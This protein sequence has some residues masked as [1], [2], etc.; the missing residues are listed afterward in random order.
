[1]ERRLGAHE[2]AIYR[3]GGRVLVPCEIEGVVD[4][5]L[6]AE[7]VRILTEFHPVL[8]GRFVPDGDSCVVRDGDPGTRR[9]SVETFTGLR[10]E[11]QVV[12]DWSAG[13]LLRVAVS[14]GGPRTTVALSLPRALVD[15]SA[16]IALYKRLWSVYTDLSLGRSVPTHVIAGGLAS[17]SLDTRVQEAFTEE[18][19]AGFL[20]S[21]AA[22]RATVPSVLPVRGREP[23]SFGLVR[24]ELDEEHTRRFADRAH[25]A[26]LS[27]HSL[28][29]GVLLTAAR[30]FLAP[31]SPRP[32][33]LACVS[34]VDLRSRISPPID[35]ES[36]QSS[37][38]SSTATLEVPESP[39]PVELGRLVAE[40]LRADLDAR[41]PDLD[42]ATI[43]R[44]TEK[45]VPRLPTLV[46]TNLHKIPRPRLPEG[47]AV[48]GW[49]ILPLVD[50]PVP[51]ATVTRFDDRL[52]VD[53]PYPRRWYDDETMR[54]FMAAASRAF[55]ETL[56]RE[57]VRD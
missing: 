50:T 40:K 48:S 47:L 56:D 32:V 39:D 8:L 20:D 16:Y 43:P 14:E 4:R 7:A 22:E 13:P 41:V 52:A 51:L 23:G 21:R 18:E 53:L 36:I 34:A 35:P 3:S 10:D 31:S 57:G 49:R 30:A 2:M 46:V 19:L 42:V 9:V 29:C 55:D 26:G 45:T 17:P 54:G 38:S 25:G 37:A 33:T 27:V 12:Q 28:V 1:M 11:L 44:L 6:L 24:L 5:A 15:G